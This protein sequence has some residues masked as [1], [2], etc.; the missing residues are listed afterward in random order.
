VRSLLCVLDVFAADY[1]SRQKRKG[2]P[3]SPA[4][5]FHLP[6]ELWDRSTL[7]V[8]KPKD[9]DG[10]PIQ[11][12]AGAILFRF[13]VDEKVIAENPEW[14]E[15]LYDNPPIP[16]GDQLLQPLHDVMNSGPYQHLRPIIKSI[17]EF[18]NVRRLTQEEVETINSTPTDMMEGTVGPIMEAFQKSE[19]LHDL[20]DV[21]LDI[22]LDTL[23]D[24]TENQ[25]MAAG[26][27]DSQLAHLE[28]NGDTS[29]GS[30]SAVGTPTKLALG[31]SVHARKMGKRTALQPP[32]GAAMPVPKRM[33][34]E[35][36][37]MG[38]HEYNEAEGDLV[39][40]AGFL[41]AL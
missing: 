7:P 13:H 31:T 30:G 4:P 33:K 17:R 2:K 23:V 37:T 21:N 8:L 36:E 15:G 22:S 6:A 32:G 19:P 38:T 27:L 28:G 25:Y 41:E 3:K 34:S 24:M 29:M 16:E 40:D 12:A 10:L 14:A 26:L 11:S 9:A 39:M 18:H 5:G 1:S 35:G 20:S